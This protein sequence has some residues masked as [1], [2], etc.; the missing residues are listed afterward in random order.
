MVRKIYLIVFSAVFVLLTA[1]APQAAQPSPLEADPAVTPPAVSASPTEIAPATEVPATLSAA[2]HVWTEYRDP[3]YGI[4]LAYPC[5]WLFTPMSADGVGGTMFLRS[6]DEQYFLAHSTK[7]N[8]Q[9]GIMPDGV[10]AVD[11]GVFEQIDPSKSNA[12]AWADM[13]DPSMSTLVA[14]EERLIGKNQATVI[15]LQNMVNHSDPPTTLFLFRL[16]PDKI[17][18]FSVLQQDRLDSNDIQGI[19][20]SLSLSPDQPVSIPS[21]APHEPLIAAAC[22]GK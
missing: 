7:G 20:T 9:D 21:V 11:I 3:R 6:F 4:G 10:F 19:L 2:S 15:Q 14:S 1:C 16:A 18:M 12:E 22:A 5:W 8:W 17:L 13:L